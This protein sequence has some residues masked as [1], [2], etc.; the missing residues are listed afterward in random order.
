MEG[1]RLLTGSTRVQILPSQ[2]CVSVVQWQDPGL[3]T[4]GCEC[5][6]HR[7]LHTCPSSKR[8]DAGLS[9]WQCEFE[10]RRA[11]QDR[12]IGEFGVPASLGRRRALVQI[13]LSRPVGRSSTRR[14]RDCAS[15]DAGASPA[16]H[17]KRLVVKTEIIA[18]YEPAVGGSNPPELT[19]TLRGWSSTAE[20]P[21]VYREVAGS[22][23]VIRASRKSGRVAQGTCLE[24]R[25]PARV[26]GFESHLFLQLP[27]VW[28]SGRWHRA[29]T[30]GV[31]RAAPQVRILPLPPT[32]TG[33]VTGNRS[34]S[35]PQHAG[36]NPAP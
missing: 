5:K 28:P 17:P 9:R 15:R 4:R 14:A 3:P 35:E 31:A 6:S 18:G 22:S 1:A 25:R 8:Q 26:R 19:T 27:E 21:A 24:N 36:S 11:Y 20:R 13:Q 32:L 16:G 2:P 7:T 29:A 10:S 23:P 33:A 12:D 30:P 34:G